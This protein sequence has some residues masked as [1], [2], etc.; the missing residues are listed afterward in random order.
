MS[1]RTVLI[2]YAMAL[3][4]AVIAVFL[5]SLNDVDT[6]SASF[7]TPPGTTGM[8]RPHAPLPPAR[9]EQNSNPI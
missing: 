2:I 8:A 9:I 7:Q 1:H 3:A 5:T 4:V 6:R